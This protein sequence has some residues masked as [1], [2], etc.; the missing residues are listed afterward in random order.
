MKCVRLLVALGLGC[1][2][3]P[4]GSTPM[5]DSSALTASGPIAFDA[6]EG[7]E[8]LE[9]CDMAFTSLTPT[10]PSTEAV[11]VLTHGF[12]RDR[13]TMQVLAEHLASWGVA[14]VTVD[15]CFASI[16]GVDHEQN[17]ADLVAFAAARYP[18]RAVHWVG[19]SA[20][21]LASVLA[22]DG[23]EATA[24]VLGLDL[25]DN[26]DLALM[27]A[28]E[29]TAAFGAL[30][31]QPS[32]C[33]AEG[34]GLAVPMAHGTSSILQLEGADHC[35]FEDPTD[36]VCTILC[37]PDPAPSAEDAE[38]RRRTART[39]ATAW[40]L[41]QSGASEDAAAWW[42]PTTDVHRS[43]PSPVVVVP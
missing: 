13:S 35:T 33:N 11:A 2:S 37:E 31:G 3:G 40:V 36:A 39:L 30:I 1:G 24:S 20:G 22:A 7:V 27:V 8:R 14:S 15:L 17:G 10:S 9:G 23:S 34:S 29:L 38:N 42:D 21:G 16:F 28:P 43:L 26:A 6:F 41:W 19:Y 4:D 18:E 5:L 32:S 12:N 25:V